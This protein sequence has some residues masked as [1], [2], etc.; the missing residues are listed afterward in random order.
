MGSQWGG[1]DWVTE[2]ALYTY[3]YNI[4][5]YILHVHFYYGLSQNT[6]YS[7]LCYIVGPYC[8]SILYILAIKTYTIEYYYWAIK[9]KWNNAICSNMNW[10]RDELSHWTTRSMAGTYLAMKHVKA[11]RFYGGNYKLAGFM[12]VIIVSNLVILYRF[13]NIHSKISDYM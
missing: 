12:E 11:G 5:I 4:Y 6:E 7:S 2:H 13:E 1:H 8:L 3:I 9:K 10:P